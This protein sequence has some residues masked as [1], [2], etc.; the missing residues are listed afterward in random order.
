MQEP[1]A[2]GA[3]LPEAL[4]QKARGFYAA[5]HGL[6][7]SSVTIQQ[8]ASSTEGVYFWAT[9][10]QDAS[11]RGSGSQQMKRAMKW[12]PDM[13]A[14]YAVLT[15]SMK[16]DFRRGWMATK[17]FDFVTSR[18]T[19]TTSFR[20]RRE[21]AGKFV[22][23]LQL[24]NILGGTQEPEAIQQASRYISM[25]TQPSLK[26]YCTQY[27]DWLGA[28]TYFWVE[29][30]ISSCN[31]QEWTNT[32]T[33]ETTDTVSGS[34]AAK[35]T[36]CKAMRAYAVH[37]NKQLQEVTEEAVASS[38]LGLKGWAE[39]YDGMPQEAHKSFPK[40]DGSNNQPFEAT[41]NTAV[42][43]AK[44]AKVAVDPAGAGDAVPP[45]TEDDKAGGKTKVKKD[46]TASKKEKEIKE[47]LAMEQS[48]DVT[49]SRVM[50]EI[51]RNAAGWSWATDLIGTYKQHRTQVL[52][53]YCDN[54]EFQS[55]KIAALS[56]KESQKL[57][58][59]F[60][61]SYVSKLVEFVTVLGPA[62][63]QM[64]RCA[65][66]VQEMATAKDVFRFTGCK[67]QVFGREFEA[68]NPL[69]TQVSWRAVSQYAVGYGLSDDWLR[70]E[71]QGEID[72]AA[73]EFR[74][75]LLGKYTDGSF[76]AAD[77]C[78]LAY[79]HTQ[80]GGRGAED[81]ALAPD[82]AST[83]GSQHLKPLKLQ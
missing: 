72:A 34:M 17:K 46:Q 29:T 63:E 28:E 78:L 7:L 43:K 57:K 11:A 58:K 23:R 56:P 79:Y 22:T 8:V 32:V 47:F 42:Q 4:Q 44:R 68:G 21:E 2:E 12:R 10:D 49:M 54:T 9:K 50:G 74:R 80:S 70:E 83:H 66:Q 15:D 27:N 16:Q 26:E 65:L 71:D 64:S 51:G 40:S 20:K 81:F 41:G 62:I 18:R 48:S 77:T 31:L 25:C 35:V 6:D 38:S 14:A 3:D 53:L 61:D 30:L 52:K 67:Q 5:A 60:G 69:C 55:L 33:V 19:S 76:T 75:F 13:A 37:H 36:A 39:L 59:E 1:A 45:S 73:A 24:T 82:Q